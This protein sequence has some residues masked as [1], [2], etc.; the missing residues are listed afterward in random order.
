MSKKNGSSSRWLMQK[1]SIALAEGAEV[2]VDWITSIVTKAQKEWHVN[3]EKFHHHLSILLKNRGFQFKK[4]IDIVLRNYWF[5][6]A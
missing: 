1:L 6:I 3:F 4:D 2:T 5:A